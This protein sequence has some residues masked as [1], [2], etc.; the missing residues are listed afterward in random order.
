MKLIVELDGD[1]HGVAAQQQHDARRTACLEAEGWD[2][3]R[4][5]NSHLFENMEGV[6]DAITESLEHR[7]RMFEGA[8][9]PPLPL[10]GEEGPAAGGGGR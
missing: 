7:R 3:I 6:L 9:S 1:T 8:G 2:V 10:A 4:F 5:W